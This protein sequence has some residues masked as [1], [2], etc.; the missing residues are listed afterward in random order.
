MKKWSSVRR[1]LF[2]CALGVFAARA[3]EAEVPVA[4]SGPAEVAL[5]ET[6]ELTL[7]WA[8]FFEPLKTASA[9]V[10]FDVFDADNDGRFV[11]VDAIFRHEDGAEWFIPAFPMKESP[12]GPWIWKVRFAPRQTGRWACVLEIACGF[13]ERL[14]S[15]LVVERVGRWT[16]HLQTEGRAYRDLY[17]GGTFELVCTES[18][19][20][21]GPVVKAPQGANPNYFWRL[22][23]QGAKEWVFLYPVARPWVIPDQADGVFPDEWLDRDAELFEPMRAHGANCLYM[24]M[25]PWELLLVHRKAAEFWPVRTKDGRILDGHFDEHPVADDEEWA[26]YAYYDQGR[27]AAMDDIVRRLEQYDER[28][29]S[30]IYLM[31]AFLP[32]NIF[33]MSAHP[34]GGFQSGWSIEDDWGFNEPQKVSGFSGFLPGQS[35][36]R[37]FEGSPHVADKGDWR[38]QLWDW[39]CNFFR[40]V[41]ARWGASKSLAA[42]I[43]MDELDAVGDEVGS[44]LKGT[45]WWGRPECLR[46]HDDVLR[47]FRGRLRYERD[48]Q[49]VSYGGDPYEHLISSSAMVYDYR[50][51]REDNGTWLGEEE[52]VDF[53]TYHSYPTHVSKGR[54]TLQPDGKRKYEPLNREL[55]PFGVYASS[56]AFPQYIAAEARTWRDAAERLRDWAIAVGTGRP[57]VITESGYL[58]RFYGSDSVN[59]YGAKYPT[60]FHY[61]AWAALMNGHAATPADWCDGKEFGEMRWRDRL[62][63]FTPDLYPVNL[64]LDIRGVRAFVEHLDLPSLRPAWAQMAVSV[65]LVTAAGEPLERAR[66]DCWALVSPQTVA[67]WAFVS[68]DPAEEIRVRV[69]GLP[70]DEHWSVQFFNTWRGQFQGAATEVLAEGGGVSFGVTEALI[71]SVGRPTGEAQD[72][73]KDVAFILRALPLFEE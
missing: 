67:G 57:L 56:N 50:L 64:Y 45:G 32:H 22:G 7:E 15:P 5:Y 65:Q 28:L 52:L 69:S 1:V 29:G 66:G 43:L 70:L 49:L 73:R 23:P 9:R 31:L 6:A 58:Q 26:S 72:D 35:V 33:K 41:I 62:G 38:R 25:A 12:D 34:W 55:F 3:L 54:W 63:S 47:F 24:W 39:Q 71:A 2:L 8:A 30:P 48:G 36:Y 60:V 19:H 11:R 27:A 10:I 46:W 20:A 53:L 17:D 14:G 13:H 44:L 21:V 51:H 42:W 59:V 16:C 68:D 4:I 37:F 40:Y 61:Q 18:P